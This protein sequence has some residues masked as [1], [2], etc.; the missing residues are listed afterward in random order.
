MRNSGA[1]SWR[2]RQLA[3]LTESVEHVLRSLILAL[4]QPLTKL[5]HDHTRHPVL[6][7]PAHE[8]LLLC[9]K[10]D[11]FKVASN[12]RRQLLFVENP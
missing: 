9:R 2:K 12:L 11:A 6:L 7:Q 5:A 4:G 10:L 3:T 8:L 1:R